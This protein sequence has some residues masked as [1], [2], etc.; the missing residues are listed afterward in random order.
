MS[1]RLTSPAP[2][3]L[4]SSIVI[5]W[6]APTPERSTTSASPITWSSEISAVV[7]PFLKTCRGESMW[8]P[9]CR[10]WF[11][12]E[13]CQKPGPRR[14]G[15]T[16]SF[17]LVEG[18]LKVF[19]STVT[20][21][22]M[23]W[24]MVGL[25]GE[26]RPPSL[27]GGRGAVNSNPPRPVPQS[28]HGRR[29]DS[30]IHAEVDHH[31]RQPPGRDHR[32]RLLPRRGSL[33]LGLAPGALARRDHLDHPLRPDRR[34]RHRAQPTVDQAAQPRRGAPDPSPRGGRGGAPPGAAVSLLSR[35]AQLHR[36]GDGRPHLERPLADPG[37]GLHP[38]RLAAPA[39]RQHGHRGRRDRRLH[40]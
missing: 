34:G 22:S 11:T 2:P 40:L 33:L 29:P 20:D 1:P 26:E 37:R 18:G 13:T 19:S 27:P 10:L 36:L 25:S 35:R 3:F 23:N 7:M 21:R 28:R 5:A 12:L 15:V 38:V 14:C 39:V 16:S 30:G 17:M 9:V 31:L 6:L 8:A 4:R 24:L 32:L